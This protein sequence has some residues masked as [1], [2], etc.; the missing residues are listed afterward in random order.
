LE[1]DQVEELKDRLAK[2]MEEIRR[3]FG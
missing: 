2:H 1:I 3:L